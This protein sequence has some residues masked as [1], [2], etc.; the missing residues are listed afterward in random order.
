MLAITESM[1]KVSHHDL[2]HVSRFSSAIDQI[3]KRRA[4]SPTFIA[5]NQDGVSLVSLWENRDRVAN[6]LVADLL[7]GRASQLPGRAYRTRVDGKQRTLYAFPLIEMILHWVVANWMGEQA[8][9]RLSPSLFSYQVGTPY[10]LAV[11]KFARYLRHHRRTHLDPHARGVFVLRRDVRSYYDSIP[12]HDGSPL[13]GVIQDFAGPAAND[14]IGWNLIRRAIRPLVLNDSGESVQL[15]R[16]I[17]TGSPVANVVANIFLTGLDGELSS[18]PGAFYARYGDD[19][20]WAHP[21]FETAIKIADSIHRHLEGR[22]LSS[23]PEKA[24]DRYLTAAGRPSSKWS[25]IRSSTAIDFLGHRISAQ[26]TTSLPPGKTRDLL[27]DLQRRAIY[28][29]RLSA[30]GRNETT[31]IARTV[32]VIN[33]FFDPRAESAHP[34]A[35]FLRYAV[36]DRGYLKWLDHELALTVLEAVFGRRNVRHFRRLPAKILR[37]RFGLQSLVRNRNR[38]DQ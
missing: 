14:P 31:R 15:E 35:R 23:H 17:P 25:E 16:G 20:L 6:L 32:R 33:R 18:V 3:A 38:Q 9:G 30:G 7:E 5:L 28:A 19:M 26:G 36:T 10:H 13:W 24:Q 4:T 29:A 12:V 27:R 2:L 1:R 34:Y 37:A 8:T 21:E 22:G 11:R